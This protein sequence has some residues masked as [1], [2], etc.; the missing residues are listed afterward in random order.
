MV[1]AGN[2]RLKIPFSAYSMVLESFR[3]M[4]SCAFSLSCEGKLSENDIFDPEGP[5][6]FVKTSPKLRSAEY[7][8]SSGYPFKEDPKT[9]W[10]KRRRYT[11]Y[12]YYLERRTTGKVLKDF[13]INILCVIFYP[14]RLFR[15]NRNFVLL[16]ILIF[17]KA[18]QRCL[19]QLLILWTIL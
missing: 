8:K 5:F 13:I 1:N 9:L 7:N 2:R 19:I 6:S 4:V 11:S 10:K 16:S 18:N 17:M 12:N 14:V 3:L 15:R